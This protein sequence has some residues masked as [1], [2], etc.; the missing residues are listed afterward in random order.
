MCGDVVCSVVCSLLLHV[1]FF[2]FKNLVPLK[3][4][5]LILCRERFWEN[6][7]FCFFFFFSSLQAESLTLLSNIG[8][9][10]QTDINKQR[11]QIIQMTTGQILQTASKHETIQMNYDKANEL[12]PEH[13]QERRFYAGLV[14]DGRGGTGMCN[15][16]ALFSHSGRRFPSRLDVSLSVF[17]Q[18]NSLP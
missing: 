8:D 18:M 15:F 14:C 1:F 5:N 3:T 17:S 10:V 4:W 11:F 7:W 9:Y 16:R 6:R 2:L 13:R 12:L